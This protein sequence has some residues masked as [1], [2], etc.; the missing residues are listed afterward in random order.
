M[1]APE[2]AWTTQHVCV[3]MLTMDEFHGNEQRANS[4]NAGSVIEDGST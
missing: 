2:E 4:S 1:R 3:L